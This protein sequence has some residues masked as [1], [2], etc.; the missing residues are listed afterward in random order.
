MYMRMLHARVKPGNLSP[1]R[2]YYIDRVIPAFQRTEGCL[3]A[4]IMQ[5]TVR[6]DECISM[7]LWRTSGNAD[8]YGRSEVFQTLLSEVKVFLSESSEYTVRLSEDLTL[9]YVP[10]SSDPQVETYSIEATA[11][12]PEFNP[13]QT[14]KLWLRTVRMKIAAGKLEEFKR[15]YREVII[16]A[17]REVKGCNYIYLTQQPGETN[18]ATSVT[19]WSSREAA[20]AYE[21]G[22]LYEKLIESLGPTLSGLYQWKMN[23]EKKMKGSVASSEDVAVEHYDILAARSF[24]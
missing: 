5:S 20:E 21:Q 23:R 16:P 4:G 9:E 12:M 3:Y 7:T 13:G 10:V 14:G 15:I 1:L 24:A 17:L 2:T 22:G 6:P 19:V 11:E 8:T 18:E